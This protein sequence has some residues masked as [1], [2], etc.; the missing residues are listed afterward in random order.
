[1]EITRK[2]ARLIDEAAMRDLAVP[3][4]LLM[5]NAAFGIF[6][7]IRSRT[8]ARTFSK[9]PVLCLAGP[10]NNG[11]DALAT[12]R[13]LHNAGYETAISQLGT[14]PAE[15][16]AATQAAII[17]RLA[18]PTAPID[19]WSRYPILVDGLFG[20]GLTRPLTGA[21]AASVAALQQAGGAIV[22]IDIPSGLDADTGAVLGV[23]V[24]ADLTVTMVAP[25]VGFCR[26]AG[27]DH[28]GAVQVVG[29]GIPPAFVQSVL[30]RA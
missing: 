15:S 11:G 27:P 16:D 18:L 25:K 12:A 14:P 10:G 1:M 2:Q 3:G 30:D 17:A 8:A 9:G 20:T 23:A 28:V 19:S 13:L 7:A 4:L 26:G 29:I 22:S 5:E 6:D 24:R 21:F